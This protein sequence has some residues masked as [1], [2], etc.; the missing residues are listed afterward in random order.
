M[1][2][3]LCMFLAVSQISTVCGLGLAATRWWGQ[4]LISTTQYKDSESFNI[5]YAYSS[6]IIPSS[7]VPSPRHNRNPTTMRTFCCC[8]PVRLGV[9][10][11]SPLTAIAATLLAYTQL[12]LLLNYESQ[13][14]TFT[15]AIRGALAGITILIALSSL[16]GLLGALFARRG[17]VSFYSNMLWLVSSFSPFWAP[18]I[19][20][21]CSE[22]RTISPASVK[23]KLT[24]NARSTVVLGISLDG[25]RDQL[26]RS[27]PMSAQLWWR[28]CWYSGLVL[29]W[30]IG[31]VT[32]Y[33]HQLHERDASYSGGYQKPTSRIF[34]NI[35]KGGQYHQT[36]TRELT[37]RVCFTPQPHRQVGKMLRTKMLITN[38]MLP[39]LMPPPLRTISLSA[40]SELAFLR[41]WGGFDGHQST[42]TLFCAYLLSTPLVS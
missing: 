33:K 18:S 9:L 21:N 14:D 3:D 22:T 6:P 36:Q 31:I 7:V 19:F 15:K 26:V 42:D 34:G 23:A 2:W 41:E 16:F 11:L 25:S 29:M 1:V 37:M 30:L 35:G 10:M 12:Y 24:E 27:S 8:I 40:S 13:Y 39:T 32:K 5:S 20:G 38:V 4:A 28:S 17:M